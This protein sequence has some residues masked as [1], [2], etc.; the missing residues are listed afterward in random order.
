MPELTAGPARLEA[1]GSPKT[2]TE[3]VG[4]VNNGQE[5]VRIA[6]MHRP[7]GWSEPGQ[8]PAFDEDTVVLRG[9]LVVE[10]GDGKLEVE[11][12][13]AVRCRAGEWV[14]Y[15]SPGSGGVEYTGVCLPAFSP[16][17]VRA[18]ER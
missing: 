17:T 5:R 13:Q 15:G 12:F 7:P 2:I 14:R 8:R 4:W 18:G 1:V 16:G 11:A 6:H 9:T 10:H 3:Y